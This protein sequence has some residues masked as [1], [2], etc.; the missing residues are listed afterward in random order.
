[1][2]I[3]A[4]VSTV[5]CT[6][7]QYRGQESLYR[8]KLRTIGRKNWIRDKIEE[9]SAKVDE[10]GCWGGGG[11]LLYTQPR[12]IVYSNGKHAQSYSKKQ[13]DILSDR[14]ATTDFA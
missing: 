6:V 4:A 8:T 3:L 13:E 1:M 5:V 10:R 12:G 11:G 2:F 9:Q 14:T 7:H